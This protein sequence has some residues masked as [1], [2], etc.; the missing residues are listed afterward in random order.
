MGTTVF[1]VFSATLFSRETWLPFWRSCTKPARFKALITRSPETLGSLGIS[2]R[3]FDGGPDLRSFWGRACDQS[4]EAGRLQSFDHTL[5]RD[6]RQLGHFSEKLRRW[7]RTP[8]L[9]R[10]CRRER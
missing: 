3:N 9:L 2:A 7:S 1:Q 6:A 4:F 10:A 5:A 8:E